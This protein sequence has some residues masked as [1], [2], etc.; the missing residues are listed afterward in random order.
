MNNFSLEDKTPYGE[1]YV[2]G[3]GPG[4]WSYHFQRRG[5]GFKGS[6]MSNKRV[7]GD[8]LHARMDS[9]AYPPEIMYF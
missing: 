3:G 7:R 5:P 9:G 8:L 4:A 6:Y 2:Q 1:I